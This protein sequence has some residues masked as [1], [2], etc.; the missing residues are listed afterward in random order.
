MMRTRRTVR[1]RLPELSAREAAAISY[2][3]DQL[4]LA[5]WA[6]SGATMTQLCERE[7]IPLIGDDNDLDQT[8]VRKR[9]R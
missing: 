9:G 8:A 2:F 1:L 6:Q 3:I 5:L 7:G 4:D